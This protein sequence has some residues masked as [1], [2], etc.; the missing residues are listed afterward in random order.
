[1]RETS[2]FER[3]LAEKNRR[4]GA[5]Q[6]K[7]FARPPRFYGAVKCRENNCR[8]QEAIEDLVKHS[9]KDLAICRLSTRIFQIERGYEGIVVGGDGVF[10]LAQAGDVARDGV[11]GHFSRFVYGAP[12]GNAPRQRRDQRRVAALRFGPEH[13]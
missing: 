6:Q 7:Y 8:S 12:V 13:D 2:T 11:L 4:V 10:V 3:I 1:R 5:L 9:S